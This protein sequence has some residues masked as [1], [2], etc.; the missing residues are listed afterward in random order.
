[1][2]PIPFR[3]S[4]LP[5]PGVFPP[6]WLVWLM[7]VRWLPSPVYSS[8]CVFRI[9]CASSAVFSIADSSQRSIGFSPHVFI[10]ITNLTSLLLL[11]G[12]RPHILG[13][14]VFILCMDSLFSLW[15]LL[16]VKKKVLSV[17]SAI[18][19]TLR[20]HLM[21][22]KYCLWDALPSVQ[23]MTKNVS[24]WD[25]NSFGV[26]GWQRMLWRAFCSVV[27]QPERTLSTVHR[28][29]LVRVLTYVFLYL[30]VFRFS[31]SGLD[32][33]RSLLMNTPRNLNHHYFLKATIISLTR[34][35]F[36]AL[37]SFGF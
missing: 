28:W 31:W 15:S 21:W 16:S 3:V 7:I 12:C 10:C 23:N 22:T 1:M 24:S 29:N 9:L 4:S 34:G 32:Q 37:E 18:T 17:E 27:M 36:S 6:L 13:H 35:L 26:A 20:P 25:L 2:P 8:V 11:F 14:P 19:D 5:V 33:V 30:T